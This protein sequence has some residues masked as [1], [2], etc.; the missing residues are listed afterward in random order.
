MRHK[1]QLWKS[2]FFHP[3]RKR[4]FRRCSDLKRQRLYHTVSPG[5]RDAQILL[6]SCRLLLTAS[7][8]NR[9]NHITKFFFNHITPSFVL[10]LSREKQEVKKQSKNKYSN[11][12]CFSQI[13]LLFITFF[14]LLLL[15][16]YV[17]AFLNII[18]RNKD[19][20]SNTSGAGRLTCS[21]CEI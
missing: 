8:L 2:R 1:R 10:M 6:L 9:L 11:I 21:G 7:Q 19:L 17:L 14:L 20:I 16:S 13:F 5:S 12:L 4:K 18:N 3:D 15:Y